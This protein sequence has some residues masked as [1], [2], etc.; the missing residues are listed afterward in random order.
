MQANNF[1]NM[2]NNVLIVFFSNIFS[3]DRLNM[4]DL[5]REYNKR[6]IQD[7]IIHGHPMYFI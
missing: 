4:D 7:N 6:K 1:E 2:S 3:Y 5:E